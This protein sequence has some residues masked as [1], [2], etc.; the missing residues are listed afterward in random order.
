MKA[1]K[2]NIFQKAKGIYPK[3]FAVLLALLVWHIASAAIDNRLILASPLESGKTLI[4]IISGN[5]LL[6]SV[7]F[8]FSRITAGFMA[9]L[10]AGVFLAVAAGRFQTI[11]TLLLPYMT[12]IKSVP[13]ASFIV[14]ALIWFSSGALSTFTSFLMTLPVIYTN[15]LEGI[16]SI[17][18]KMLGMAAVFRVPWKRRLLYIWTPQ[19]RPFLISACSVALGLAWKAGIAAEVIGIPEGSMGEKLYYAKV[20]FSSADL[21][22]WTFIIVIL[23]LLFEKA[24]VGLLKYGFRRL[25]T[26]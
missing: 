26:L 13:V 20:Y 15:T 11:E 12:T 18:T 24:F 17:D 3:L 7:W 6:P 4:K 22:A 8:S 23:S 9:A 5:A 21:L 1:K 25:F 19:I 2:T 14:L 16:K 10:F